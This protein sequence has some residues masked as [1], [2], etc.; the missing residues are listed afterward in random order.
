M[1]YIVALFVLLPLFAA[2]QAARTT[3][4]DLNWHLDYNTA[5]A[6]AR[7][8]DKNLLVYFTG[9]D[10]CSPCKMLKK[11][12]FETAE[13]KE[14]TGDY[15][16]LYVDIPRNKD[17]LSPQQLAHN[18]ALLPRFNK[19]TVFPLLTVIDGKEKELDQL[20]GYNMRGEISY[21]MEF[22]RKNRH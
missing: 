6:E 7:K 15:V 12:L 20:S 16:L 17:L 8:A 14:A 4:A 9:S 2:G 19:R 18:K 3:I 21:H 22:I 1:K 5:I 13:F 10:W 11:D